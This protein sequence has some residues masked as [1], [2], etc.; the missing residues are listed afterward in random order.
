MDCQNLMFDDRYCL[1]FPKMAS[2]LELYA[3]GKQLQICSSL[4][5][6]TRDRIDKPCRELQVQALQKPSIY[7]DVFSSLASGIM[8]EFKSIQPPKELDLFTKH[9]FYLNS[10]YF[11]ICLSMIP[12]E[13][14]SPWNV[15]V[16]KKNGFLTAMFTQWRDLI[17]WSRE[18][19]A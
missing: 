5:E 16:L 9:I 18:K 15:L 10:G 11:V 14:P 3:T 7:A 12:D 19:G 2:S 17:I 4:F 13:H 1:Q 6:I 8:S